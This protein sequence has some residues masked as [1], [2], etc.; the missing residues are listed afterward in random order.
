M[1]IGLESMRS[2]SKI[3]K[4][5]SEDFQLIWD[6]STY[7]YVNPIIQEVAGRH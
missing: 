7:L 2:I 5:R 4:S 3:C 1:K 6:Y